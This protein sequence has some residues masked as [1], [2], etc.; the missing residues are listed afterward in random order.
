MRRNNRLGE[1]SVPP[2][3]FRITPPTFVR[4]TH[5]RPNTIRSQ[6]IPNP[7]PFPPTIDIHKVQILLPQG[8]GVSISRVLAA[9][10]TNKGL[11][12]GRP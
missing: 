4:L 5:A 1:A 11:H 7:F 12:Q 6:S 10:G 9:E 3:P 2:I 8:L